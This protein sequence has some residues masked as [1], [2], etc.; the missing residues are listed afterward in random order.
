MLREELEQSREKE[1]ALLKEKQTLLLSLSHDLRTPLSAIEL[2]TRALSDNLYEEEEKRK[3]SLE[4]IA[5]S[6]KEIRGY[7]NRI[8][9]AAREEFLITAV[10]RK[11]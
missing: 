3:Q 11:R 10:L 4:G 2:Y 1:L 5:K 7:A 6:A 8:T 9:E